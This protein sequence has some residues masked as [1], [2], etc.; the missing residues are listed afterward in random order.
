M[1]LE[2]YRDFDIK[3][4]VLIEYLGHGE[5]VIIP[6]IVTSIHTSAFMRCD[7]IRS[8]TIPDSVI[9]IRTASFSNCYRLET[10][11]IGRCVEHIGYRAFI[12]CTSLVSIILPEKL[13]CVFM[14]TFWYCSSLEYIFVRNSTILIHHRAFL[15]S[16]RLTILFHGSKEE[17]Q[18]HNK[19]ELK[20]ID[21]NTVPML[22]NC[23]KEMYDDYRQI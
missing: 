5:H 17:W 3:D 21:G 19:S 23:T 14:D 7:T 13:N 2:T 22:F 11:E 16:K 6:D 15:N 20:C 10:V 1:C 8:V 18:L 9:R 12:S 4:G